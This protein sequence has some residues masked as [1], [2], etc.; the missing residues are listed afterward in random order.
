MAGKLTPKD[1]D[2]D[3][4]KSGLGTKDILRR[5]PKDIIRRMMKR[6]GKEE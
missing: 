1:K 4:P 3:D 2:K 6:L 5:E